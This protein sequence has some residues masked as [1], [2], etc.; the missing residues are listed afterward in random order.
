MRVFDY[1]FDEGG[2]SLVGEVA[3]ELIPGVDPAGEAA[4]FQFKE[5]PQQAKDVVADRPF[6]NSLSAIS[7]ARRLSA[8]V[9]RS[10]WSRLAPRAHRIASCRPP[11]LTLAVIV[12]N[13]A[14]RAAANRWKPSASQ[15][16]S[17][18]R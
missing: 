8:L 13:P 1:S 7:T 18:S 11:C 2:Q 9:R 3:F 5:R 4:L 12:S 14:S 17:P 16:R 10:P 15:R 6:P